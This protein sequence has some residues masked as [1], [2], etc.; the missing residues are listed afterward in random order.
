[1]DYKFP[2]K[3]KYKKDV[4]NYCLQLAIY[5]Y[6]LNQTYKEC[7]V[8]DGLIVVSPRSTNMLYLY[9]L[10]PEKIDYYFKEATEMFYL[11]HH[12][13]TEVYEWNDFVKQCENDDMFPD[14]LCLTS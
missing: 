9:Y 13:L 4:I 3:A 5:K 12:G 6:G 14:R 1:M 8:V 10:N 2:N 7:N 11:Y